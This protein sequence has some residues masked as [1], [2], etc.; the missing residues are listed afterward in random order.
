MAE[1]N[2]ATIEQTKEQANLELI[3]GFAKE[4]FEQKNLENL[5]KYMKEAYIQHNPL[6]EQGVI[7]FQNFFHDWF[8]AV[9]D[10]AYNLKN[11]IVN[12]EFVWV[13]GQYTGTQTGEWLGIPATNKTYQFDAVDI[14]RI[15][16]G[17]LAEHWDVL[18]IHTLFTQ[19]GVK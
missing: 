8:T 13:Y 19:L 15:E 7:G 11:I 18:D 16:D 3:G 14:F 17:K 4:V 9:P 10:F 6:V 12:D 1:T 5:T 2:T